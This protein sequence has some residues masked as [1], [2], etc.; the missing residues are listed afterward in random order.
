MTEIKRKIFYINKTHPVSWE[1]PGTWRG[2]HWDS[3]WTDRSR[4]Q[5]RC[6][7][8]GCSRTGTAVCLH[9]QH[10]TTTQR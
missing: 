4:S 9:T 7:Q 8:F 2:F 5:W 3:R 1:R 6:Y 10:S